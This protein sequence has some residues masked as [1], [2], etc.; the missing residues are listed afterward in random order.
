MRRFAGSASGSIDSLLRCQ[1]FRRGT[2]SVPSVPVPESTTPMVRGP[3]YWAAL[4]KNSSIGRLSTRGCLG[5][6][7]SLS[8]S[9]RRIAFGGIRCTTLACSTWPSVTVST[10]IVVCRASSVDIMLLWSGDRCWMTT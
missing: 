1:A 3:Q 4:L 10:G 5:T 7:V 9:T 8:P 6:S 2:S